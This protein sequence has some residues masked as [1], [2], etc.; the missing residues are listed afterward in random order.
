MCLIKQERDWIYY[1]GI[2]PKWY[3]GT[4]NSDI[5]VDACWDYG[6][7]NIFYEV[8]DEAEE[9]KTT[10]VDLKSKI[11]DITQTSSLESVSNDVT[12]ENI[13]FGD[14]LNQENIKEELKFGILKN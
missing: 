12:S 8:C 4:A 13:E 2:G 5:I 9:N 10:T 7:G 6:M 3:K 11:Q 1:D 14:I